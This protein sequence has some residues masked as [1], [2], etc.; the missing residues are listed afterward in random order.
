MICFI[1]AMYTAMA[2][3]LIVPVAV[4]AAAWALYGLRVVSAAVKAFRT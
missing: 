3:G 4:R 2:N 1:L